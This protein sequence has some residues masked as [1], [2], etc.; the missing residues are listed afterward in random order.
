MNK[1]KTKL[2]VIP[3]EDKHF[4]EVPDMINLCNFP[5]PFRLV[6]VG[7]PN[8]GKSNTVFNILISKKPAFERIIILHND[9]STQE[10]QAVDAEYVEELPSIDKIDPEV[11][12]LIIVED[13]D[14]RNMPGGRYQRSLLDRYFGVFSTHHNISIIITAQDCFAIPASIRR[15]CSH[16]CMWRNHDINSMTIIASRFGLKAR[17]LKYIFDHICTDKHDSLLIDTMR[18][19]QYRLR[20]NI[21]ECIP[22]QQ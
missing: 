21:Y 9:P 16:V 3:N 18:D 4:H 22:Y 13:I 5:H 14:Y 15:M 10:Y 17:D 2:V 20:K 8:V 11:K 1:H 7:P 6:L 12:H 19:G